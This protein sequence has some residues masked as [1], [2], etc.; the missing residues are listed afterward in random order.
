MLTI[1]QRLYLSGLSTALPQRMSQSST[2]RT[3]SQ[4]EPETLIDLEGRRLQDVKKSGGTHGSSLVSAANGRQLTSSASVQS[5]QSDVWPVREYATPRR[6][7]TPRNQVVGGLFLHHSRHT[8][9]ISCGARF[10]QQLAH[11][12]RYSKATGK[13]IR[14]VLLFLPFFNL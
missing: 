6:Y 13:V 7:I 8:E 1:S 11:A 14:S 4:G 5:V 9:V 2:K 12:C 3:V 10:S